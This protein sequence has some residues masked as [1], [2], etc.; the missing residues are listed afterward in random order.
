MDNGWDPY[1]ELI[2]HANLL[3]QHERHVRNLLVH[4][5]HMTHDFH[6]IQKQMLSLLDVVEAMEKKIIIL[7][8]RINRLQNDSI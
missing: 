7:E 8:E 1:E 5:S 2:A 6:R 3:R 4:D